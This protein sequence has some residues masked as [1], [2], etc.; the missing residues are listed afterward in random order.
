MNKIYFIAGDGSL[1]RVLKDSLRYDAL[2]QGFIGLKAGSLLGETIYSYDNL[3]SIYSYANVVLGVLNPIYRKEIV[4][5]LGENKL[6]IVK[7]GIISPSAIL[8]MGSVVMEGSYIMNQAQI[9]AFSHVH[10]G[11]IIGHNTIIGK[12]SAINAGVISGGN[13]MIGNNVRIGIGAKILPNITIG[14]N[15]TIG[16]GTIVTK[17]I[18]ENIVVVGNPA[19]PVGETNFSKF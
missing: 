14:D 6:T 19:K 5:Q 17:D 7:E 9:G 11:A 10:T 16:A 13:V 1:A 3:P 8:G 15:A 4:S 12:Y 2:F 18:P